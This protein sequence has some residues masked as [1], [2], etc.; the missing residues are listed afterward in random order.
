MNKKLKSMIEWKWMINLLPSNCR[1]NKDI[2]YV[3]TI[4]EMVYYGLWRK[5][6]ADQCDDIYLAMVVVVVLCFIKLSTINRKYGTV[7]T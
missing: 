6:T 1:I 2:S 7:S 3:Q 5:G 4:T